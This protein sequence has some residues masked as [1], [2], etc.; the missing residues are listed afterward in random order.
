MRNYIYENNADFLNFFEDLYNIRNIDDSEPWYTQEAQEIWKKS[1]EDNLWSDFENQIGK[2]DIDSMFSLSESV[3]QGMSKTG[4]KYHMDSYWREHFKF[5]RQFNFN[6]EKWIETINTDNIKPKNSQLINSTD[7]FFSFNY[8]DVLEN[9]YG[10]KEVVHIHGGIPSVC[11]VAPIM[12]HC[13]NADIINH[14]KW[15]KEAYSEFD[16][17]EAS[18]QDAIANYLENIYKDTNKQILLN[19]NFFDNINMVNSIFIIGWSGGDADIPYLKEII[20]NV[21]KTTHWTIYYY[22]DKDYNLFEKLFERLGLAKEMNIKFIKSDE[23][24]DNI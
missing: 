21:S 18:I 9:V 12:G 3:T 15:A 6:V 5:I 22:D 14:R 20:K 11:D 16:E 7:F 10:I 4:V 19:K 8:T 23:F 24:W 13:N 2:P 17:C 1:I